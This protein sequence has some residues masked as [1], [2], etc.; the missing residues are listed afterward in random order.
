MDNNYN[1]QNKNRENEPFNNE[2]DINVPA[3]DVP[4]Q[5]AASSADSKPE[6]EHKTGTAGNGEYGFRGSDL[7]D[8]ARDDVHR[9]GSYTHRGSYGQSGYNPYGS[10]P[11]YGGQNQPPYG[12]QNPNN[13]QS[14]GGWNQPPRGF[15]NPPTPPA[16]H[17]KPRKGVSAAALAV[18]CVVS[19][20]LSAAAGFGGAYAYNNYFADEP[21]VG[22]PGTDNNSTAVIH[23]VVETDESTST[24]EKGIYTDVAAT[25]HDSVVEITTEFQVTGFFQ[26]V[27]EGAGS[28]V[29]ISEDGYIITN[30][31]VI[32]DTDT[33]NAADTITVRLTNGNEYKASLIGKDADSDIAIIKIEPDE[34]LT[35]AVFGDSDKLTIG[36]EV[37]AVGNPLGELGGTVTNGIISAL[38]REIDVDGTT[39]NLLQTNAAIN[40]GNSGGGL[41]NMKGELIGV[42]NAKSSGSGI[43][44]LGFAIPAN[45]ALAV[46]EQ[47]MEHGYVTGKTFIGVSFYDVTDPYTAYRYFKSQSVGVYVAALEEGYNDDVLE[48]GD[49]IVDIEGNEITEFAQIKDILNEHEVGDTLTFTL[50]RQGKLTEVEVTC[51]EYVPED[52]AVD[53]QGNA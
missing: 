16:E 3:S 37:I 6:T 29:I 46:A 32:S 1:D 27:S 23:R 33:G 17:N 35:Y 42:V 44:G 5:G 53:F 15:D 47:L 48:Y 36:E 25:V 26:Y 2:A 43:E 51:Y 52:A 7:G 30:N 22:T 18:T 20:L 11:P 19:L 45:D 50:Y 14:Y 8:H 24:G 21:T 38:D 31:H 49:R 34:T 40:P 10:Q 13:G 28:G 4:E 41:F 39:M 9:S 12:G